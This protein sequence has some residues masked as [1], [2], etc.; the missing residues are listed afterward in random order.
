MA[1][2]DKSRLDEVDCSQVVPLTSDDLDEVLRLYEDAYPGNW[3]DPRMLE[4][5]QYFGER[6]EDRLVSAAGVH[7][8]SQEYRVAS[9]GNV[10]THPD[11]RSSG[12]GKSTAARL[13]Q[14][15]AET[16]DH[17]G[18]NVKADNATAMSLYDKLG[19]EIVSPYYEYMIS[20]R[21]HGQ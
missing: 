1:L 19:F 12:L 3:F 18:L 9:L 21:K 5:G 6:N 17:I 2:K 7:V 4:T 16:V 14:S 13:C 11:Y 8:Y 20:M 15:L 10:V